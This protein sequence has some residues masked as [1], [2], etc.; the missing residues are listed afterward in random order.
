VGI[1]LVEFG[2][3]TVVLLADGARDSLGLRCL[4]L[5]QLQFLTYFRP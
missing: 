1:D 4:F 3:F 5:G 2:E